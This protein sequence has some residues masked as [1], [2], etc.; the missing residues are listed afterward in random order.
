[1]PL[2]Q[3]MRA[4]EITAPGG[5]EVLVQ[6]S[7]PTPTPGEGEVLIRV[8][9]AGVNRPDVM[10]RRGLYPPPEGASPIPGL[11]I[12]G[13]VVA[14]GRGVPD[15]LIGQRVCAL[16]TGGGYADYCIAPVVQC[17]PV[18]GQRSS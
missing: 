11:E 5:A 12:A 9:A 8:A 16:V 14:I 6:G 18:P 17:L 1:M 7:I 13:R 3:M 10:Q 15:A 4:I 2:P